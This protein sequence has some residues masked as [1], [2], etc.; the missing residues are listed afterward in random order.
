MLIPTA[1]EILTSQLPAYAPGYEQVK[2]FETLKEKIPES[3]Y[4]DSTQTLKE[5]QNEYIYYK[6]D[7][8]WTT[9]GAYYGYRAYCD[10]VGI[11]GLTQDAFDVLVAT[12]EFLGT[13]YSK[14]N[15]PST[16]ADTIHYYQPKTP[17]SYTVDY[18]LGEKQTD[19]L[20]DQSFLEERDK[21]S[22]FLG[23]NNALVE[24]TSENKNG[25]TLLLIKD[26]FAHSMVPFLVNDY[27]TILMVDLRYY[28]G[29][30]SKLIE[31]NNV[32]DALVLYNFS[33]LASDTSIMKI[34]K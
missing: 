20:Y 7:H 2:A 24:I 5:H 4:V 34:D 14:A 19:T 12:D 22:F 1:A 28:N 27:E 10:K 32:T 6:T 29:Q 18:N 30:M 21:Y 9:L 31:D 15:L 17:K 3:C 11:E 23:G 13:I 16:H 25:K 33:T 26:S 8:H